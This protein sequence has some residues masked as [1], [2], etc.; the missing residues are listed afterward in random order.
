MIVSTVTMVRADGSPA[1][2]TSVSQDSLRRAY[3]LRAVEL[4]TT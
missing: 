4:F 3:H 1:N 2:S